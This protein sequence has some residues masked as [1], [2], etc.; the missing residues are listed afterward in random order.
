M[1]R[2]EKVIPANMCMVCDGRERVLMENRAAPHWPEVGFP[3]SHVEPGETFTDAVTQEVREETGL[4]IFASRLC[5]IKQWREGEVRHVVELLDGV[6]NLPFLRPNAEFLPGGKEL[7][8][9]T[10]RFEGTLASFPEGEIFWARWEELPALPLAE[11]LADMLRVFREEDLG[12]MI[13]R[14]PADGWILR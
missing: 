1:R 12:E 5:G 8:Y 11:S 9:K 4:R 3:G 6:G 7:L 2:P 10:D 14:E 13:Y